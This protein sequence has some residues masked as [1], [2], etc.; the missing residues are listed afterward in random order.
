TPPPANSSTVWT[1][2]TFAPSSEFKDQCAVPRTGND[3]FNENQPYPDT[4]GSEFTEKMWLRSWS[5]ETYLWYDEI[6]DNNPN[7]FSSV[8]AYYA[9]LKTFQT[10]DSGAN[11]DNFHFSQPTEDFFKESQSGVVSGY[12]INWAFLSNT[13]PRILRIAY[14]EDGSPAANAGLQRGDTILSADNVSINDNTEAGIEILNEVLFNPTAGSSHNLKLR[15]NDGTEK[16]IN[17]VA[18]NIT[19]TPVQNVNTLI[20]ENGT[21]VGYIQFN[22]HISIAQPELINAVNKFKADMI[23][24]LVIDFRYNG[25]GVLALSAQLAYMVAGPA[26]SRGFD[27]YQTIRNDKQPNDTPFPFI[28]FEID[29]STFQATNNTLPDLNLSKVY[30]LSTEGTCSASEALINGLKGI[31]TEVVLIG[32]KTCGKP[33]G[34]T[35]THNCA[36]TYYTIQLTGVNYKGFGEYSDGLVP[37]PSPQFDAD[38]KGCELD[39]DFNHQLGDSDETLLSAA[40]YHIENDSCPVVTQSVTA[41]QAT[42]SSYAAD[43]AGI[44]LKANTTLYKNN[45]D[46][47]R[48]LPAKEGDNE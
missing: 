9:Q 40:L 37:T 4:A 35:P 18:G 5:D 6:E 1:A 47:T 16:S 31:D 34:F 19:Q 12:G 20:T 15:S 22:S 42:T 38:V 44:A 28:D 29:Y 27:Y 33:Y 23:D 3:P 21:K 39:D 25:G 43:E 7:D 36:T 46:L 24:E 10:T 26:N 13:P 17:V 14:L 48:P 11:K 32:G 8:A 30:V 45:M 2:G 41:K